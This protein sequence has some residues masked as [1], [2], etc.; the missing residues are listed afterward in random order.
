MSRQNLADTLFGMLRQALPP[1]KTIGRLSLYRR[2][3]LQLQAER[4]ENI[5]SHQLAARAGV[6]SAQV[7]RDLM[8][9]GYTGSPAHGYHV[10]EMI[11]SIGHLLDPPQPMGAALVGLG[12]L[13]RAIL[14]YFSGRRPNLAIRA[15]FDID[16]EKVN[17]VMQG[18][19]C[20]PLSELEDVVRREQILV[21]II[22]TP[23][24]A[25][26]EVADALTRAGVRGLMNFAPVRLTVPECIFVEDIDMIMSLEKVAFYARRNTIRKDL[27][28]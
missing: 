9:L 2:L 7:R 18:C 3:L 15:A 12:N 10:A 4:V 8:S 23:A 17:R 25:A 28:E 20:H 1:T 21:G 19:R 27:A 11:R 5:Y 26:Q 24:E 22:C 14:T 13:G 6:T 16:P